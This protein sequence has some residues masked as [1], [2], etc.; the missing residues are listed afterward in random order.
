[1]TEPID[2]TF[3]FAGRWIVQNS[4]ATRV[5]SHGTPLFASSYATDFVPV[6]DTGPSRTTRPIAACPLSAMP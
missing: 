1:M 5:S 6:D 4:P 3:P 2:L